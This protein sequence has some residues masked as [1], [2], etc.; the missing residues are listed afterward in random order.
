MVAHPRFFWKPA[1]PMSEV[2]RVLLEYKK[3]EKQNR[4]LFGQSRILEGANGSLRSTMSS[5]EKRL[6]E[7][8]L[9][10]EKLN[11]ELVRRGNQIRSLEFE[12]HQERNGHKGRRDK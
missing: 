3:L 9:V 1:R 12:L 5:L 2:D 8:Q 11:D 6:K 7:S 10:Q 4:H